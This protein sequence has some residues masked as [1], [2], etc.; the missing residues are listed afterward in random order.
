MKRHGSRSASKHRDTE[1]VS[2]RNFGTF[3][4]SLKESLDNAYSR[5]DDGFARDVRIIHSVLESHFNVSGNCL[6]VKS[7]TH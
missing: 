7:E 2:K 5:I 3:L 1:Y 6:T 4:V